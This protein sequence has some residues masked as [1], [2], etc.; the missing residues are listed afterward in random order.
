MDLLLDIIAVIL[1]CLSFI[2]LGVVGLIVSFIVV[3][4]ILLPLSYRL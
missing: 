2:Y 4:F 1:A 3:V